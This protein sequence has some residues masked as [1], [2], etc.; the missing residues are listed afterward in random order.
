MCMEKNVTSASQDTGDLL[1]HLWEN[2]EASTMYNFINSHINIFI[3]TPHIELLQTLV[4]YRFYII[5]QI[6]FLSPV[7]CF[8]YKHHSS[9]C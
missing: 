2:A 9:G 1:F 7:Q 8:H 5:F 6:A 3:N 4:S